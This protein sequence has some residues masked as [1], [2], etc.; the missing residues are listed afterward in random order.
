[1]KIALIKCSGSL[2]VGNEF[3]NAGGIYLVKQIFPHDEL[4]EYEFFDSAIKQ[5]F[6][7]PSPALLDWTKKQIEDECDLMFIFGGSIIS[8]YTADVLNELAKIQVK[9]VLLGAG[10]YQYDDFDRQLCLQISRDY[11]YIFTRDDETFSYFHGASNVFSGIDLAFFVKDVINNPAK[12]GDY[13]LINED[14]LCDNL[15]QTRT[16]HKQLLHKYKNVYVIENTTTRYQ[17]V[18]DFLQIGYWDNL[19]QT[20]S[21]ANFVL[22]NRIHTVVC[23]L[24]NAVPFMYTGYDAE[25]VTGRNLL[26]HKV[27]FRLENYKSYSE[28]KEIS[29]Q[30]DN[31]KHKMVNELQQ[32]FAIKRIAIQLFGHMRSFELAYKS[33]KKNIIDANEFDGYVIDIFIHTWDQVDHNT[34]SYR[35]DGTSVPLKLTDEQIGLAKKLYDPKKIVITPQIEYE[36]IVMSEKLGNGNVKRSIRGCV[37]MA[38]SLYTGSKLRQEYERDTGNKYDYVLVT[39]PDVIFYKEVKLARIIN[40]YRT[41]NIKEP[42]SVIF[43]SIGLWGRPH[44]IEDDRIMGG[45]DLVFFGRPHNIDIANSVYENFEENIDVNNFYCMEVWLRSYWKSKGLLAYMAQ[46]RQ[47]IEFE[48]LKD[49]PEN[50]MIILFQQYKTTLENNE[51]LSEFLKQLWEYTNYYTKQFSTLDTILQKLEMQ[52]VALADKQTQ[53]A[54][55]QT[56]LAEVLRKLQIPFKTFRRI[57]ALFV[58]SKQLRQKLRGDK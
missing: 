26:F 4:L 3:I 28:C 6:K 50:E 34:I 57:A 8:K 47:G 11:D 1:M 12:I 41:F 48:L 9:K 33:F 19:Y 25:G 52:N 54:D 24:S 18:E 49:M 37:N 30:I 22:T 44:K 40:T 21:H 43:H 53:L 29:Q 39:R 31:A 36:N 10:A 17:E 55:K 35:E 13:A 38:F 15:E 27:G 58:P 45:T 32:L 56:Q 42:D 16:N 2:N 23:C 51:G 14:L 46:I 20:I 5:N 7:Y